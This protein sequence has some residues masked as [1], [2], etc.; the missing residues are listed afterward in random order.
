MAL[1]EFFRNRFFSKNS[2][3]ITI[4]VANS[5]DL[6]QARHFV[7]PDLVPNCLQKLSADDTSR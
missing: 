6:D 5:L 2:F 4:R 1:A 3:R 7:G